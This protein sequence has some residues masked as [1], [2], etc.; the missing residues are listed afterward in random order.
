GGGLGGSKRFALIRTGKGDEPNWLI[1]LMEFEGAGRG[2]SAT[3]ARDERRTT[4]NATT[5]DRIAPMLASAGDLHDVDGDE[6][7]F[8]MKWDGIR[9]IA[10]VDEGATRLFSRNGNELTV[11]YPEIADELARRVRPDSAVLDGELVA[12]DRAGRPS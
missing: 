2:G 11:T 10:T 6:W 12:L 3:R 8:E 5:D 7:S 9:A 1:H 4:A